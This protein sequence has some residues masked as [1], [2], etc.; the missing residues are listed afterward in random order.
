MPPTVQNLETDQFN[1][2][3]FAID[4]DGAKQ[5]DPS[6]F[7]EQAQAVMTSG[8]PGYKNLLKF[9]VVGSKMVLFSYDKKHVDVYMDLP[10]EQHDGELMCAGMVRAEETERLIYGDSTSLEHY[11]R[12]PR[13]TSNNFKVTVLKAALGEH[14]EVL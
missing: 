4:L 3:T 8:Q 9:V 10:I 5:F 6:R 2:T 1:R 14:F 12:F 13:A 7:D 11:R